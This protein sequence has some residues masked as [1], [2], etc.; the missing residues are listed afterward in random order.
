MLDR[1]IVLDPESAL[2]LQ[3]QIRQRIIDNILAGT[4]ARGRRLP[5]S[6]ALARQLG[7]GR[8]TVLHAMNQLIAEGHLVARERSGVYVNEHAL[9]GR[10]GRGGAI[11]PRP[12]AGGATAW[13]RR[14]RTLLPPHAEFRCPP[15]WQLHP[16]PFIDGRFDASLF[17]VAEWREASRLALGARAIQDWSADRGTADDPQLIEELRTKVLPRRGIEARPEEILVTLGAQQGLALVTQLLLDATTPVAVE[18]PGYPRMREL[19]ALRGARVIA[20]PLDDEGLRIDRA[21]DDARVVHVTPSHQF[22]TGTTM[23]MKRRHALL[24]RAKR[25]DFVII[26]DDFECETTYLDRS[27]PALRSLDR[28]GRVIYVASLSKV[29]SPALRLGYLVAEPELIEAAR[30]LRSLQAR[31][32]PANNQ[33]AA[34]LY[35]SLGHYDATMRRLARVFAERRTALLDALNHYLRS[36]LVVAPVRGGTTCWVRGPDH[37]DVNF[38]AAQAA[39]HGILIEPVA[40]YFAGADAP[41]NVFRLGVTSLPAE[42]IREGVARLAELMRNLSR[43]AIEHLDGHRGR[44]LGA[45]DLASTIAG[46]TLLSRTVYGD[47]CTVEIRD[48]GRLVGRAGFQDEDCDEGEWWVEGGLFCR[49]WRSWCYGETGRYIPVID[50]AQIKWFNPE[51]RLIDAV[52]IRLRR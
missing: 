23:S 37:L 39:Q 3:G 22:P 9:A 21:L 42:R 7:V 52:A 41:R 27:F 29:L 38:L 36:A 35:I 5:S 30:A 8:N 17:P 2:T 14:I 1:L 24:R 13:A 48:D 34:A 25:R 28:S 49:R 10:V 12:P 47:P 6:R 20:Q 19:C 44:R 31:Q 50:G 40:H 15:N 16:F 33:R 4:F 26:E 46:A 51:G 11:G 45:D 32:P 18:D 43:D